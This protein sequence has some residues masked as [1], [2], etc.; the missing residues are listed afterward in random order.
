MTG[1]PLFGVLAALIKRAKE[2]NV[3]P[4]VEARQE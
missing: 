3:R 1:P 2:G 4:A